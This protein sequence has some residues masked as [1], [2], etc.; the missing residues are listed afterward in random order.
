MTGFATHVLSARRIGRRAVQLDRRSVSACALGAFLVLSVGPSDGGYYGRATGTLTLA[1][2]A[3]AALAVIHGGRFSRGGAATLCVLAALA[4]WTA[5]SSS[6]AVSGSL[7]EGEVRRTLLYA[8]ALTAVLVGVDERRRSALLLGVLGGISS[9]AGIAISMRATSG[10]AVDRFYGTLLEE[11]VGYPNAL[12]VLAALGIVLG[13]GLAHTGAAGRVLRGSVAPL[14]LVLG[15]TGSRGAALALAVG[16]CALVALLPPGSRWATAS[17]AAAVLVV[18][19]G[20]WA[21]AV[22]T[23]A[24]GA[25]LVAVAVGAWAGAALLADPVRCP[26]RPLLAAV[27]CGAVI[28][29]AALA[30]FQP[31]DTTSSFRTAYWRVALEETRARPLLGSGAGS[32]PVTWERRGLDGVFVRDAHSLYVEALSELGPLGLALTLALVAIPIATAIRRHGD[33]LVAAAGAGF[34]V[35]AVHAGVDWDW[36]MPV[37]TLAGLGCAAVVLTNQPSRNTTTTS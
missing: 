25:W 13:L 3:I 17:R 1:F 28:A 36:E 16:L 21:A 23:D 10:D 34:V 31:L 12:G 7:V 26:A 11:P 27:A 14:V 20:A 37:V 30:A 19:G 35:F 32:F 9:I 6:W 8:S 18:G 22:W 2:L 5:L 4:A 29:G 24:G 15:L 33:P